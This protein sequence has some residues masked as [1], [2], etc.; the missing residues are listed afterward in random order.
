MF[1][2]N[3]WFTVLASAPYVMIG[4]I[5]ARMTQAFCRLLIVWLGQQVYNWNILLQP[6]ACL[7]FISSMQALLNTY[8]SRT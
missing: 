4:H 8:D 5:N 7:V 1:P 6:L 2:F 3:S